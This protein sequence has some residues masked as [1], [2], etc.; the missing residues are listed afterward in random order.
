VQEHRWWILAGGCLVVA[1]GIWTW[2]T[3]VSTDDEMRRQLLLEAEIVVRA[4]DVTDAEAL[5]FSP[6][7]DK[8]P[9]FK[10]IRTLLREI[11]LA[12]G[13][14]SIYTVG[15]RNGELRF[16]PESIR[17]DDPTASTP[18]EV[19][20]QPP[21][22]LAGLFKTGSSVT[23]GP[24]S[25]EYGD[26]V[27]A[28]VPLL[29][30]KSGAVVLVVG[31][32][33][34]ASVWRWNV[35]HHAS[36]PVLVGALIGVLALFIAHQYR[37]RNQILLR[38]SELQE[39]EARY[40][41]LF[42]GSRDGIV[43][44]DAQGHFV[45]ANPAF[46]SMLGYTIEE[47]QSL[48]DFHALTP[49]SWW[50]YEREEIWNRRLMEEGSSGIYEKEY[51]RRDGT[52]F[53][54]EIQA[55]TDR[56]GNGSEVLVWGVARDITERKRS[57]EAT[58]RSETKFRTL[59]DTSSDAV[60]L[61][62]SQGFFDCNEAALRAFG[63]GSRQEFAAL[64]PGDLAPEEQPSGSSSRELAN[65][66][67]ASAIRDG[68]ARFE[69][70]HRRVDDGTQFPSE[71]LLNSMILDGEVVV[72]AVVRDISKR[73]KAEEELR[74][75]EAIQRVLME[76]MPVGV[77]VIDAETRSIENVNRTFAELTGASQLEII[78]NRCHK[79][80]CPAEEKSCPVCDLGQSVDNSERVVLLRNGHTK[81]ILKS[82][83]VVKIKGRRKL[84]E[85]VVDISERKRAEE[86]VRDSLEEAERLNAEL[87]AQTARANSMAAAAE[88]ANA[89]KSRF[90]ANMSHEIRT[91]LNSVVGMADLLLDTDLNSTQR[92]YANIIMK[93]ADTLLALINDILDLSK[94]EADKLDLEEIDFNLRSL[95][96]ELGDLLGVRAHEKRLEFICFISAG[97]P[98]N[99]VGD[100]TRLRQVIMNLA[101]NAI[102]FTPQGEVTVRVHVDEELDQ[103]VRLRFEVSDTG[104]GIPES[105]LYSL[106]SPFT[107][108]DASTTREYGGTGLG[109]SI[110]K[111][112]VELMGGRIGVTSEEGVGSTF[113][114]T[115]SFRKQEETVEVRTDAP[116]DLRQIRMLV[117]DDNES[118][119]RVLSAMLGSWNCR[120]SLAENGPIALSMIEEAQRSQDPFGLVILDMQMPKMDGEEV[121]RRLLTGER[122]GR[123]LLMMLSSVGSKG[124]AARLKKLGFAAFLTK[125]IKQSQLYDG[126]V[127]VLARRGRPDPEPEQAVTR[128]REAKAGGPILRILL[129]EDNP[130]N[131][132]VAQAMLRKEGWRSMVAENGQRALDFLMSEHFDL[133]LMDIQMPVMDGFEA[134]AAIRS[135][136]PLKLQRDIPIVAMTANALKGDREACLRAGM[137]DYI[138]KPIKREEL[139]RVVE[140][141][142]ACAYAG[143]HPVQASP[144]GNVLDGAP[145]FDVSDLLDRLGGDENLTKEIVG[146]FVVDIEMQIERLETAV[147]ASDAEV[148]RRQAHS[149]KGAAGNAGALRMQRCAETIE[150]MIKNEAAERV[151]EYLPGLRGELSL[152]RQHL[153]TIGWIHA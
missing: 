3:A 9:N 128:H 117:V 6:D 143:P 83:Q 20:L 115:A 78:G 121:A 97:V 127:T 79:Y 129:V 13:S 29:E 104:I 133:V 148:S 42:E 59:Y 46:C 17:E 71:V 15:L 77:V 138:S 100:P 126:L 150:R 114:F 38:E 81:P 70:I 152:L 105:V 60:M 74:E 73:K 82:V 23:V 57:A 7:D 55:F 89:A 18:G 101:G 47:L 122:F 19:Y 39:S 95:I 118:N 10:R 99:L 87:E 31:L 65:H 107:Q 91:P 94:I 27:S 80:V 50:D 106:F 140:N 146:A 54:V 110:S 134:T 93:G 109:L 56:R 108:A 90:L 48:E 44:V 2:L 75:S 45:S 52:V 124:D 4:I 130:T 14:G 62:N 22:D 1:V 111:R 112:L 139:R 12:L 84:L 85:C 135:S 123:P 96:E 76:S 120:F 43:V 28:F 145:V 98:V 86:R 72:Q 144:V 88:E 151:P 5:K 49:S 35:V 51:I 136:D 26:F 64:H 33:V 37:A 61:L 149:I 69:W 58:L 113:W 30:P 63:V 141:V 116:T 11:S 125:P 102:K 34:D 41:A 24:Y 147:K 16:G 153:D 40:R 53:P 36:V 68:S 103:V 92:D 119:R 132:M 137:N 142:R 25:D 8:L 67:I 32:D 131:Q 66:Y 21:A